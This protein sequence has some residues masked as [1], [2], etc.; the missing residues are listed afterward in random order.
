MIS[1]IL[2]LAIFLLTG[3]LCLAAG[4]FLGL[5]AVLYTS[6][7]RSEKQLR[8]AEQQLSEVLNNLQVQYAQPTADEKQTIN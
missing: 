5:S 4:I 3:T 2:L 1:D 8:K 6:R 7:K